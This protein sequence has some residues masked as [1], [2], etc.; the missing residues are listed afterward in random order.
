MRALDTIPFA[1]LIL[2]ACHHDGVDSPAPATVVLRSL[3]PASFGPGDTVSLRGSGLTAVI[4]GGGAVQFGAATSALIAGASDT[5]ARAVAP[6]CLPGGAT[7]VRA[8][9]GPVTSNSLAGIYLP[10]N[11][12]LAL[13]PYAAVTVSSAQLGTCLTLPGNGATYLVVGQ[14]A[15]VGDP[16]TAVNWQIATANS[17]ALAGAASRA[18]RIANDNPAERAFEA[19]LRGIER[20]IAPRARAE[21]AAASGR[22]SFAGA[23]L[24]QPPAIGSTRNFRV[25][26]ALD[27]SSFTGA[28]GRL[29]YAGDHILVYADTIGPG[30]PDA[31]FHAL[32]ALFDKDLYAI[33]INAFGSVSD[34]DQNGRVIAF[35]T[36]K[37]NA[38]IPVGQCA[39]AGYVTGFFYGTDLL[40]NDPNS[41]KGEIF[42]SYVP[43][44]AGTFSCPHTAASVLQVVGGAFLHSL[45]H[46]ISFNQHVLVRR[47]AQE[48]I[49]LNEGLG[50]IAEELG[51][52]YYEA[53]YPAPSGRSTTTQIFPDSA[54]PFI[55]PQLL[56]AY[57]YLGTTRAHS[58]TSYNGGGS[59]EE[60]GATWLFLR[61]LASQKGEDIFGRLV[62]TSNTGIA[63]IEA[64]A[65]ESFGALFGDFSAALVVDSIPG[66]PR[67]SVPARYR[68]GSRN[69]RLLMAR[70]AVVE[71]LT[72][73]WPLPLYTLGIGGALSSNMIPGTMVHASITPPT[74]GA[75]VTLSFT[76]AQAVPFPAALGAQLT[77][78]R[79]P[80]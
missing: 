45:Q 57:V 42:Y 47:G 29:V 55:Q 27:G 38:L 48:E 67:S 7:S 2:A 53:K 15:S 19:T 18:T 31:Q 56:Q 24:A 8:T 60:R 23:A 22:A 26:A 1:L 41:N 43:D 73:P 16:L 66:V 39:F 25:V 54:G 51:S 21:A 40:L 33:D 70:E 35:F 34:V 37:I 78:F 32:G 80:P 68:F 63:N 59:L 6:P 72:N 46:M 71:E 17:G 76:G 61:W 14:F 62:Q 9:A 12:A 20:T 75:G 11:V 69:L 5:L 49:W 74:G 3:T 10:H 4:A 50:Q 79:L 13:A 77:I 44:S 58:V 64:E 36:P 28:T 65:G 52:E 30:F